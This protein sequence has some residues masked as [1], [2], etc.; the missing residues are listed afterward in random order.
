MS[1]SLAALPNDAASTAS[2]PQASGHQPALGLSQADVAP[3]LD[4]IKGGMPLP[5]H[6]I[7]TTAASMIVDPHSLPSNVPMPAAAPA[8]AC[9]L[10]YLGAAPAP[11]AWHDVWLLPGVA[12]VAVLVLTVGPV[13]AAIRTRLPASL[14]AQDGTPRVYF[15]V[16]RA[17]AVGAAVYA[18]Q[19]SL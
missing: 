16:L 10:P 14:W 8:Q 5:A 4:T 2:A 13:L 7:P 19:E 3:L 17:A 18:V 12:A 11:P 9:V 1:T 15:D 6:D